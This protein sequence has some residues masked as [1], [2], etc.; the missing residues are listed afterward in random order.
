MKRFGGSSI[1]TERVAQLAIL[2]EDINE[3]M[4]SELNIDSRIINND[5]VSDHH[6][7]I[8]TEY[9]GGAANSLSFASTCN[10]V[11]EN[12]KGRFSFFRFEFT[13][14]TL[15][16][17]FSHFGDYSDGIHRRRGERGTLER[18]ES[19]SGNGY[20]ALSGG[21]LTSFIRFDL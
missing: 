14:I 1:L 9:I 17:P 16:V 7:I 5:K 13:E 4:P 2:D 3:L 20:N 15:H 6:A 21:A 18:R 12:S 8:P 19:N 11:S 10:D